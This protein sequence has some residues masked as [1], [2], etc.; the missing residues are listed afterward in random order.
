MAAAA[1][2]RPRFLLFLW[3][4]FLFFCSNFANAQLRA[5]PPPVNP[6]AVALCVSSALGNDNTA[7][8]D[9]ANVAFRTLA[10]VATYLNLQAVQRTVIKSDVA[11][12]LRGGSDDAYNVS[13]TSAS[14]R[15]DLSNGLRFVYVLSLAAVRTVTNSSLMLGFN[16]T[17]SSY[18]YFSRR[19]HVTW[20]RTAFGGSGAEADGVAQRPV[21]SCGATTSRKTTAVRFLKVGTA[22]WDGV[23]AEDCA[24]TLGTTDRRL[25]AGALLFDTIDD[26]IV[27]RRARFRRCFSNHWGGA[28]SIMRVATSTLLEELDLEQNC[29]FNDGGGVIVYSNGKDAAS[30]DILNSRFFQN[31]CGHPAGGSV[32]TPRGGGLF[33]HLCHD[34]PALP[35]LELL[36]AHSSFVDNDGMRGAAVFTDICD[37]GGYDVQGTV[38]VDNT[39]F[40]SNYANTAGGAFHAATTLS[41]TD[42]VFDNNVAAGSGGA[43]YLSSDL[44]NGPARWI[45]VCRTV[46]IANR[47][48]S[49]KG[50]AIALMHELKNPLQGSLWPL[51]IRNSLFERNV[52][53]LQGGAIHVQRTTTEIV[54][55]SF[56][57]NSAKQNGGVVGFESA[58]VEHWLSVSG[59]AFDGNTASVTASA[60]VCRKVNSAAPSS[61]FPV[62]SISNCSLLNHSAPMIQALP[63][64]LSGSSSCTWRLD[65]CAQ[66]M[67]CRQN[68]SVDICPS[69]GCGSSCSVRA[70]PH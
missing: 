10:G 25:T 57:A 5:S 55:S 49:G 41:V 32:L 60:F 14:D 61:G 18:Q 48:M 40:S 11:I 1:R 34:K 35:P 59:C 47:A 13:G 36:L 37:F 27:V 4:P 54:E 70:S 6:N 3:T 67:T 50:G 45:E 9:P 53:A 56:S 43:V 16:E 62:V 52:A 64:C 69:D 20:C 29:A 28:L 65:Q 23:D 30:V 22:V 8:L 63:S 51:S 21:V 44:A 31:G 68:T 12:V 58:G 2:V 7:P 19:A 46:F 17:T 38:R 33:V 24:N 42:S 26:F 15:F 66:A 39:T